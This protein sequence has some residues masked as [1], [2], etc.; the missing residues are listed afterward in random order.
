MNGP[1]PGIEGGKAEQQPGA[2]ADRGPLRRSFS[3]RVGCR[4]GFHGVIFTAGYEGEVRIL[5]AQ[6]P[7]VA[8][9]SFS[10]RPIVKYSSH[11]RHVPFPSYVSR[12]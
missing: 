4:T 1:K 10:L 3:Y 8:D 5:P 7:K 6:P 2:C 11:S 12:L 9:S